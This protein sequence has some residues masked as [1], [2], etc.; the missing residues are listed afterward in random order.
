MIF[1]LIER[2]LSVFQLVLSIELLISCYVLRNHKGFCVH[3]R[4]EA[5]VNLCVFFEQWMDPLSPQLR[6]TEMNDVVN[7]RLIM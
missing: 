4:N 7:E 6:T 1:I 5:Y 2:I 3:E